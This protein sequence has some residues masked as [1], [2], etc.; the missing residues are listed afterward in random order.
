MTKFFG[1]LAILTAVL[2]SAAGLNG[3]ADDSGE[4]VALKQ[5]VQDL[6]AKLNSLEGR[7]AGLASAPRETV[8]QIVPAGGASKGGL[9]HT[10]QDI[11]MGG[12]LDIEYNQ[13]LTNVRANN[14]AGTAA[15]I[16]SGAG[17]AAAGG[18]PARVF[19][20]SQNSF[21]MNAAVL[22]FQKDPNP[23]GGVGFRFDLAAGYNAKAVDLAT[24]GVRGGDVTFEQAYI[25]IVAPLS[26][27]K[28]NDVFD[29]VVDIKVGRYWT[30][31]GAEV[32]RSPDNWN[33]S[34][35]LAFGYALPFSHTGVRATYKLFQDKVTTYWGLN[36]GWDSTVDNNKQK[37]M[38]FGVS[39]NPIDNVT[40]TSSAYLGA[41]QAHGTAGGANHRRFLWSNVALWN[42]TS[43]L[44]LMGEVNLGNEN[45]VAALA[46]Q[47][48]RN[49]QWYTLAG[50]ARYKLTDKL[51][52]AYRAEIFFDADTY[53]FEGTNG[54]SKDN[55]NIWEQ[56]F[57]LE[58]NIY[59]NLI[60]RLEYRFDKSDDT[61]VFNGHTSQQTI[62][63]QL[64]YTFA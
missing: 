54:T 58:Y 12:Y 18:N 45:R 61:N 5:Q 36:N 20:N 19:D 59:D 52:T 37:T 47:T 7:V 62:G 2:I 55:W 42:A 64:I 9:I 13:N 30:L 39:L 4:V 35:S 60:G 14:A 32:V 56:T 40:L 41:E 16:T 25:D 53:R 31:A 49:A 11:R 34:R 1:K 51:A 44:S 46:G 63:G 27:L 28:G 50:Y 22:E 6:T 38:E 33:I 8:T 29:D 24:N 26:F 57:T 10:M 48:A 21:T 17:G 43:K 23:E 15:T 3:F